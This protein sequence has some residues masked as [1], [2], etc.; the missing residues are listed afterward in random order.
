MHMNTLALK[1]SFNRLKT[2]QDTQVSFMT[3]MVR[4]GC[5]MGNI[6]ENLV[7]PVGRLFQDTNVR[8]SVLSCLHL[9]PPFW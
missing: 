4:S 6:L 2:T 9:T 8:K 3:K 1:E 5:L 7:A